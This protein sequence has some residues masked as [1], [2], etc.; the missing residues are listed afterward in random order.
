MVAGLV[1][2]ES[3]DEEEEKQPRPSAQQVVV[4]R[5]AP[6]PASKPGASEQAKL[7]GLTSARPV[8]NVIVPAG[9]RL[10]MALSTPIS[11]ARGSKLDDPITAVLTEPLQSEEKIY[12]PAGAQLTGR[13]SAIERHTWEFFDFW[14]V[15]MAFDWIVSGSS[16]AAFHAQLED[17]RLPPEGYNFL[18]Y[19]HLQAT[20]RSSWNGIRLELKPPKS[21]EGV[22]WRRDAALV[23][24]EGLR[25]LWITKAAPE[26]GK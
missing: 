16:R 11:S 10:E 8:P 21:N 22:F 18:P 2:D 6:S 19:F 7:E 5:T 12:F 20:E 25:T 9:L 17:V 1:T 24:R 14:V 13:I 3:A 23:L 4:V 15:G 26:A